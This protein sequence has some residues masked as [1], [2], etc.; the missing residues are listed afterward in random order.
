MFNKFLII[1]ISIYFYEIE[2][3]HNIWV[4]VDLHIQP[5]LFQFMFIWLLNL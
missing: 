3:Y 4:Q 2:N 1:M 5:T